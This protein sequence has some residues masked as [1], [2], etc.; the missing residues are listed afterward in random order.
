MENEEVIDSR[1]YIK[2]AIVNLKD[3]RQFKLIND[4][5]LDELEYLIFYEENEEKMKNCDC[6]EGAKKYGV[7]E[8]FLHL[9]A[10]DGY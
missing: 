3:G 1:K 4:Y 5:V 6:F 10:S 7:E 8:H 9:L 2:D